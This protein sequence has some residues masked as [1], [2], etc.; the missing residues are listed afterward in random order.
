[1][2]DDPTKRA[3]DADCTCYGD[4]KD[5]PRW[6]AIDA[7]VKAAERK[8][9][10]KAYRE[11]FKVPM[12]WTALEEVDE[13]AAEMRETVIEIIADW[14]RAYPLDIFPQ[15][16]KGQHGKTVDA[17]SAAMARHVL[18]RLREK[19]NALPLHKEADDTG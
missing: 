9:Y 15:P 2:T 12:S 13:A 4:G 10:D 6:T 14:E 19:V 8:G 18:K 7:A 5:R 11:E 1:M 17:C 16:P 3:H